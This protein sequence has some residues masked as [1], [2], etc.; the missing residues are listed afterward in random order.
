VFHLRDGKVTRILLYYDRD[1]ALADLGLEDCEMSEEPTTPDLE[2]A[3][4][5]SMGA[6]NRRDFDAAMIL[7]APNAVWDASPMGLDVFQGREAIR[8]FFDDWFGSYEAFEQVLEEFRDLGNG[9][10]RVVSRQ[11]ARLPGSSG[12]V[13]LRYAAVATWI[14]GLVERVTVYSDGDEARTAAE[15]LAEERG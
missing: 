15:R 6:V 9:V 14:D 1:R 7:Y 13:E 11:R 2:E 12:F 4:R 3:L 5:R 8:G 10:T